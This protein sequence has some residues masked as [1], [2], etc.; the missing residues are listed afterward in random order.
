[1]SLMYK[2]TS[3][4]RMYFRIYLTSNDVLVGAISLKHYVNGLT[5]I[6]AEAVPSFRFKFMGARNDINMNL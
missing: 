4:D 5:I 1:M 2:V 3:Q 6:S